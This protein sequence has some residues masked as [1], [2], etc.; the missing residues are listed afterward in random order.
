MLTVVRTLYLTKNKFLLCYTQ[1]D[2]AHLSEQKYVSLNREIG[3]QFYVVES[4][5]VL[6]PFRKHLKADICS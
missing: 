6:E 2:V 4:Y 3:K 5:I 1:H